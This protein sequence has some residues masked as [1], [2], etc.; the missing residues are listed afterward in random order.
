[1]PVEKVLTL[2]EL[3]EQ[4]IAEEFQLEFWDFTQ[5]DDAAAESLS[6]HEGQLYLNALTSLSDT[7]AE[8]LGNHRGTLHLDSLSSLSE[9]AAESLA[10]HTGTLNLHGLESL[11]DDTAVRLAQA[12]LSA[13]PEIKRQIKKAVSARNQQARNAARTGKTVL[14]KQQ[15]TKLRKLLRNKTADNVLLA[16]QLITSAE[17]TNDDINDVF[18]SSVISLL[19]NTRDSTVWFAIAPVLRSCPNLMQEFADLINKRQKDWDDGGNQKS[20]I[21]V[22]S[23]P[24]DLIAEPEQVLTNSIGMKFLLVESGEFFMGKAGC[25]WGE[26]QEHLVRVTHP[27]HLGMLQ[28]TQ[29]QYDSVMDDNPSLYRGPALPVEHLTWLQASTFAEKLSELSAEK[30]AGR[31]YRLPTEAEWE[32]ACRAGTTTDFSF[33]SRLLPSQANFSENAHQNTAQPT[34]PVG[35]FEPNS[36]GFYDMHGNVWEWCSDWFDDEYFRDSPT[37]DPTG[38]DKGTHHVLRGGAASNAGYECSSYLRGEAS[39]CDGPVDST[40]AYGRYE[41]LGDFGIRLVCEISPGS[42]GVRS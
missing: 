1:M 4:L 3:A 30:S 35:S 28:V 36:W 11:S 37:S 31:S 23:K 8:S 2:Q 39:Q 22:L 40:Y 6:K 12:K 41:E 21:F 9:A 7:A 19:V 34:C 14:T 32:F 24:E 18:S 25:S 42:N 5:L 13:S 38:P 26:N 10:K 15:A 33:G 27:F 17:A 29:Q 16:I 20:L